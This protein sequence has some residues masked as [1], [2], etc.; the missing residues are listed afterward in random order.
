MKNRIIPKVE[1]FLV[2]E[3]TDRSGTKTKSIRA[4][5]VLA[6]VKLFQKLPT[7][8]FEEKLP[9][10]IKVVSS[11]LR[12]RDSNERD[13]ARDTMAK[14]A[15]SLDMK[16]LP[17]ILSDISVSLSFGYQ[18]HVRAATLHSILVAI[19]GIYQP[20]IVNSTEEAL[21]ASFDRCVP[22]MLDLIQQDIFG[23]SREMKE[24]EHVEKR[25][26]KEAM[27]SK[28][29][30]SL[31]IISR[32]IVFKPSMVTSVENRNKSAAHVLV[33]PFIER[34]LDSEVLPSSI[35]KVKECLSRIAFGLS[36]NPS[37]SIHEVLPFIYATISPFVLGEKRKPF[38]VDA[39]LEN[40]DDEVETPLE[41]SKS[42]GTPKGN[43][44]QKNVKGTV[45]AVSSWAPSTL[46]SAENQRYAFDTKR[47]QERD[48]LF[49]MFF[50]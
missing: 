6:L 5:V 9:R 3:K 46:G 50:I 38:N 48:L 14:I 4:S 12:N 42:N 24:V 17:L 36:N 22:A 29:Q 40:S 7:H 25:M 44:Q 11:A 18:L 30:D 41:V 32:L 33:S 2:K 21:G 26:I 15:S 31:E 34:L 20:Q 45:V 13:I 27:G 23:T 43:H 10:L 47:H 1:A 16:Y 37:A 39:E 49:Y 19:S 28:S 8:T 35:R